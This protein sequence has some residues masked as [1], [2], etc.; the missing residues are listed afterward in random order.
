MLVVKLVVEDLP[1]ALAEGVSSS[2]GIDLF[3][4]GRA[5]G[6]GGSLGIAFGAI[7]LCSLGD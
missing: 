4:A 3:G 2:L 6:F 1:C 7:G 5:G